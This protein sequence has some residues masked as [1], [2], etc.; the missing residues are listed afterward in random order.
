MR[1]VFGA[2]G[3]AQELLWLLSCIEVAPAPCVVITPAPA[4][5]RLPSD[6]CTWLAEEDAIAQF[7]SVEAD[8]YIAVGDGRTRRKIRDRMQRAPWRF[9]SVVHGAASLDRRPHA[10]QIGEGSLVYPMAS[11][12]TGIDIGAFVQINPGSTIGHGARLGSYVTVCPGAHVSGGA[13]IGAATFLGAGC[14]IR[15]GVRIAADCIIGAGAVVTRD[16]DVSGT[17]VG[18]PARRLDRP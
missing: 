5:S 3:V 4:P 1:L 13:V 15:E 8:A 16:I 18:V 14:V 9:P 17:W 11:L 10:V 12:T 7:A 2:G 6:E